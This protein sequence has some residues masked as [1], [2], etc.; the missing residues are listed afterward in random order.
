MGNEI[1]KGNNTWKKA[2][3]VFIFIIP[4]I[5]LIVLTIYLHQAE[6]FLNTILSGYF[7]YI[8]W[9]IIYIVLFFL[10]KKVLK[11]FGFNFK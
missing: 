10:L 4:I 8:F 2:V 9:L 11:Y 5:L 6:G 3:L 1:K 7:A